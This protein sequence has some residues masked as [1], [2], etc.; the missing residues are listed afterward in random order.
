[1]SYDGAPTLR[2]LQKICAIGG[3]HG[4]GRV[5]SALSLVSDSTTGIVATT[6]SGGSSGR[7][8]QDT[9]TIAWGDIRNCLNQMARANSVPA[10]LFEYRFQNAGDL[11]D[12][13][14][15]NLMLYALD[16][17]SARPLDAIDHARELLYV[18]P[19]L[20]P[21]SE[22]P[23]HLVACDAY[24]NTHRGE[25]AVAE[26]DALPTRLWLEPRPVPTPSM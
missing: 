9:E 15:G 21:M 5:L 23:L 20:I 26:M 7:I 18:K 3:G 12:H 1:M 10:L 19:A 14:L 8:R 4:L 24:G 22:R 11:S 25:L 6:D 16:Q 13:N 2:G 17:L